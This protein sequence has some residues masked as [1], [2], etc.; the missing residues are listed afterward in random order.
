[1]SSLVQGKI[2][3]WRTAKA[4]LAYDGLSNA[5]DTTPV[6]VITCAHCQVKLLG[7]V[8]RCPF[9]S[10]KVLATESRQLAKAVTGTQNTTV[11]LK[12]AYKAAREFL[13]GSD[14]EKPA[15]EG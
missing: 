11:W 2:I 7:G 8:A 13:G 14:R 3:K 1:M 15:S 10:S 5:L 6:A 12:Q 4:T 9:K